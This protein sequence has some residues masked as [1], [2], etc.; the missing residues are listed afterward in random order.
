MTNVLVSLRKHL[1]AAP[2]LS[3][4]RRVLPAIS[5]TEQAALDAGTVG[6][7]PRFFLE[8]PTGGRSSTRRLPR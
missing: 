8:I 4:V 3:F 1:V 2:L 7:T 5:E 6:G